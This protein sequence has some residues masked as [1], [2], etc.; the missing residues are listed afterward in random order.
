MSQSPFGKPATPMFHK[1]GVNAASIVDKDKVRV[2][3][4][5]VRPTGSDTFHELYYDTLGMDLENATK[6]PIEEAI[7]KVGL[8][9]VPIMGRTAGVAKPGLTDAL[10]ALALAGN[11]RVDEPV[12]TNTVTGSLGVRIVSNGQVPE[13]GSRDH[14]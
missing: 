14:L 7:A 12:A 9:W 4:R 11:I 13:L 6:L 8:E 2:V 5:P 3:L 1:G 10:S